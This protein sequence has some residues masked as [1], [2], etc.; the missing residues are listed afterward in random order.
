MKVATMVGNDGGAVLVTA[1]GKPL[2]QSDVDCRMFH[3]LPKFFAPLAAL[4]YLRHPDKDIELRVCSTLGEIA[5]AGGVRVRQP[6]PNRRYFVGGSDSMR[7]G[8]LIRLPEGVDAFDIQFEW[9]FPQAG[10]WIGEDDD[11][12]VCHLIHVSLL[13]GDKRLYTMDASCWP[14]PAHASARLRA[15]A[16]VSLAGHWEDGDMAGDCDIVGVAGLYAQ[17][18][19]APRVEYLVGH[20]IE[21]RLCIAP[22]AYEQAWSLS[23]FDEEQIHEVTQVSSFGEAANAAHRR[24]ACVEMPASVMLEAIRLACAIPFDKESAFAATAGGCE[25]HP[26]MKAL[27]DWWAQQRVDGARMKPGF[28]MP[29]VRVREDGQYWCGYHE[30]PNVRVEDFAPCQ[31][32]AARLGDLVLLLFYASWEHFTFDDFGAQIYLANG[33]RFAS[34]GVSQAE[35]LS[36]E[37]DEAWYA[38][39]ALASFP[40]RFPAAYQALRDMSPK[41][42]TRGAND[43]R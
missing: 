13:P 35:V 9:F 42:A 18:P 29:W 3:V 32:A 28:A 33:Q 27:T 22:I 31:A 23:A 19:D 24:N 4:P 5:P 34:V 25:T 38:L 16:C 26:A 30:T 7:N 8:W 2:G 40:A 37:Y 17:Y 21:E 11:W 20:H 39:E 41:K 1:E 43:E 12:R 36:G 15:A 14:R 10:R 6:Y